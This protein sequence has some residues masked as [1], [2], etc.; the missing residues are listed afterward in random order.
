M[1]A[2]NN[3]KRTIETAINRTVAALLNG[4]KILTCGNG[5]SASD[6]MHFAEEL[7]G[8]YENHD[9]RALPALSLAADPCALT[10]IANDYGFENVF[11]RQVEAHGK[12]GD[13][14]IAF[15]TSGNSPNIVKAIDKA[16]EL[17]MVTILLTGKNGGTASWLS[18]IVISVDSTKTSDIQEEHT[19]ITHKFMSVIDNVP[20]FRC[21]RKET[22]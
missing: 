5:G 9:R 6:S 8:R 21:C 18:K 19:R 15:S 20:E 10:C 13:V 12:P 4:N 17:G 3:I 7:V 22:L 16:N 11:K 14:L 1:N 2:E